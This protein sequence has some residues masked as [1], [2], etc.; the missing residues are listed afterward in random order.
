MVLCS[1]LGKS[2]GNS[3]GIIVDV[4]PYICANMG[5]VIAL[6]VGEKRIGVAETDDLQIIA[7]A[8]G[9]YGW[10]E[11][12]DFL[13]NYLQ[14]NEVTSWVV[15]EPRDLRNRQTD[16]EPYVQR[17]VHKLEAQY[18]DIPV[19]RVDERF[20]SKMAVDAMLAGGM[21][22]GK[23]REKGNIDQISAVLILQSFLEQKGKR[24]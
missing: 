1:K 23:R 17:M 20:T 12:F 16:A 21:K 2:H 7:S 14:R 18:P 11:I 15:G 22:K 9:T 6:D 19:Y 10:S 4:I 8:V 3:L 24:I 5:K 13:S